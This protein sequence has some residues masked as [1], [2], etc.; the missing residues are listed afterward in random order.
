YDFTNTLLANSQPKAQPIPG[1]YNYYYVAD[2][3]V[4]PA[5]TAIVNVTVDNS[6][7]F[8]SLDNE[9][10]TDI[11]V[12]PNPATSQLNIVNP[13]NAA[14]LQVEMLD[15]NGRIVLVEN[16]AL[17]NAKNASIAIDHLERGIYT[18]R[19]YNDEGQKTFK[20]VKQ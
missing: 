4:C 7:D 1:Q 2:N 9:L 17:D 3:G 18:L 16:K 13:S 20:V 6:C 19:V 10:F 12:F 14:S 11:S 5:D 8:L 15:M